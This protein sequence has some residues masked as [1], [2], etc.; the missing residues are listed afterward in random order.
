MTAEVNRIK[1]TA[2][3]LNIMQ[4]TRVFLRPKVSGRKNIEAPK[5]KLRKYILIVFD[6]S[7][8]SRHIKS[9]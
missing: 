9:S 4:K 1:L 7:D 3:M 2:R 5:M 6:S 8:L